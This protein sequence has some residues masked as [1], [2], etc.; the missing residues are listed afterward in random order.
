MRRQGYAV[1]DG[2]YKIGLRSVSAP[3]YGVD[4]AVRCTVGI[5][6]ILRS[7]HSEEF[8]RAVEQVTAAGRMLSAALGYTG[9]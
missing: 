4:S 1:E 5:V 2:E 7:T 6:G 3:V 9:E 8:R